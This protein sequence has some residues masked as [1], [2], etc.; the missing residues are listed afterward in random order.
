[1]NTITFLYLLGIVKTLILLMLLSM[2]NGY[3]SLEVFFNSLGQI[4]IMFFVYI[5]V[6]RP[7]QTCMHV[8]TWIIILKR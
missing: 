7:F 4:Y 2:S 6:S 5:L 8:Y 1:M 3:S